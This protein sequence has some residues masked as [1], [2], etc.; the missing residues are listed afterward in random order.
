MPAGKLN[1]VK[2]IWKKIG[3][4]EDPESVFTKH[5]NELKQSIQSCNFPMLLH[6]IRG[7]QR[8]VDEMN[9][10]ALIALRDNQMTDEEY[11]LFTK[12]INEESTSLMVSAYDAFKRK[13]LR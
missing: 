13:C 10:K 2:E 4:F 1:Q 8:D 7:F 5:Y 11:A 9:C 12:I 6:G 3:D